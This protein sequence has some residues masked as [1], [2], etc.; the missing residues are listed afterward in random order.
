MH[1]SDTIGAPRYNDNI[2]KIGENELYFNMLNC[3][4]CMG[5]CIWS[6]GILGVNIFLFSQVLYHFQPYS[7]SSPK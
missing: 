3:C 5:V 2:Y 7:M 6:G 1:S 4:L